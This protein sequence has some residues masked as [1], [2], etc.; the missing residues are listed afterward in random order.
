MSLVK[1][2]KKIISPEGD[3]VEIESNSATPWENLYEGSLIPIRVTCQ[4]YQP[5]HPADMS[6]HTNLPISSKVILNHMAPEHGAGG[7]FLFQLRNRPGQKSELWKEL[8]EAGVEV[9]DLRCDVCDEQ[10]PM[11]PRRLIRHIS[12]HAGKFRSARAGGGFWMTLKF[13]SPEDSG[14]EYQD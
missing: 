6:C 11:V 3:Q 4:D 12:A 5:I 7:G 8:A 2:K 9:H 13:E 1:R 14:D 10:L